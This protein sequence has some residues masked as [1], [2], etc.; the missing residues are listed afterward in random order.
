MCI[1]NDAQL[2]NLHKLLVVFL[3]ICSTPTF[4]LFHPRARARVL[5][6][7]QIRITIGRIEIKLADEMLSVYAEAIGQRIAQLHHGTHIVAALGGHEH[8]QRIQRYLEQIGGSHVAAAE[9][10]ATDLPI[11]EVGIVVGV[12]AREKCAGDAA[13]CVQA[14]H[15]AGV[16]EIEPLGGVHDG[17]KC[18]LRSGRIETLSVER[19]I[20][21]IL[22][23]IGIIF[24]LE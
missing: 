4:S 1:H 13:V 18:E 20:G 19:G 10:H 16:G 6:E 23:E 22:R 11:P 14:L 17:R 12:A 9:V 3:L 21:I 8:V 7:H 24:R 5:F 2:I 15:V